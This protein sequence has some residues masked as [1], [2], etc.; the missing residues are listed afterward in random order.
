MSVIGAAFSVA[1]AYTPKAA[2]A[3]AVWFQSGSWE[4]AAAAWWGV[5]QTTQT[6]TRPVPVGV[7]PPTARRS[8][9]EP[10]T[11]PCACAAWPLRMSKPNVS[12]RTHI[13]RESTLGVDCFNMTSFLPITTASFRDNVTL[14]GW[15]SS[16]NEWSP[17]SLLVLM[18]YLIYRVI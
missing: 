11:V 4:L 1:L 2:V 9:L 10:T 15:A 13:A 16:W 18:S 12:A 5:W 3:V 6:S 8:C 14:P 7:P 17:E